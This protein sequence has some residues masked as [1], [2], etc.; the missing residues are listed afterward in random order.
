MWDSHSNIQEYSK[1]S[2]IWQGSSLQKW[3]INTCIL[4]NASSIPF[5]SKY[6]QTF[7]YFPCCFQ[8]SL[9][10]M[11]SSTFWEVHT[12]AS[13]GNFHSKT[14]MPCWV[15]LERSLCGNHHI[16]KWEQKLSRLV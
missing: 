1:Y 15:N 13:R 16:S 7:C 8:T 6:H 4:L 10:S 9:Q 11:T 12:Y 2:I 14:E 5:F 3:T